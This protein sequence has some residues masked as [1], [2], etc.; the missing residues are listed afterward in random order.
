VRNISSAS[1]NAVIVDTIIL[2]AQ[3]LDLE[4]VAEGIETRAETDYLLDRDCGT[5]QGF[6]FSRPVPID[7]FPG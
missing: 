1:S 2:M 3:Q 7:Q 4:V 5:F 6:F